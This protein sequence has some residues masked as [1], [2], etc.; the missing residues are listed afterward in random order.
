MPASEFILGGLGE[1][2][3]TY[4]PL[5]LIWHLYLVLIALGLIAGRRMSRRLMGVL[6][7]LPLLSVSVLA[8]MTAN[9][10]NGALFASGGI[11]LILISVRMKR[12]RVAIAPPWM[13][14]SGAIMLLF[15]LVYPHFLE[16]LWPLAY[17]YSAP[18]GLI[19]CPT[20]SA[21]IGFSLI[22]GCLGSRVWAVVLGAMG[23]FYGFFGAVRLGVALDWVL[24]AGAVNL[25]L[26]NYLERDIYTGTK[27]AQE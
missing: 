11:A 26:S 10:F 18:T 2:S 1:I 8:W 23:L 6:L 9:P 16:G 22:T 27:E 19:P 24:I 5:A 3:N 13:V 4:R 25:V 17:I 21:L 12:E 7:T 14:V 15:G 20:L